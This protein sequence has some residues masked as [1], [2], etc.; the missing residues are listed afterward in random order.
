VGKRKSPEQLA[1]EQRRYALA[2]AARTPE[3]FAMFFDDPNQ[4]IRAAAANNPDADEVT[5]ARFAHDRFWGTR[6]SVVENPNVT[7]EI[8]LR[9][10]ESD[11]RQRGVSHHAAK[12]RLIAEGVTFD[13]DGL[14]VL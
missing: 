2:R 6:L 8:L 13:E 3:E 9:M 1:D 7:H 10:L 5:L 12:D 14:P 4:A 11:P